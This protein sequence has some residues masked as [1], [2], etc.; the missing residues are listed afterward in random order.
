M[1]VIGFLDGLF[2]NGNSQYLAFV[3]VEFH[4][5]VVFP[6]LEYIEVSLQ[7][8]RV[9]R[10]EDVSVKEAVIS[11]E[12]DVCTWGK[13]FIYVIYVGQEQK[14]TKDCALRDTG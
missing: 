10:Y 1:D 11:E 6:G 7:Y 13:V 4:L 12:S 9:L 14:G 3:R 2:F 8:G 5:V